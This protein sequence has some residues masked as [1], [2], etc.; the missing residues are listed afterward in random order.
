MSGLDDDEILAGLAEIE[1]VRAAVETYSREM[2]AGD[3]VSRVRGGASTL[4]KA[5]VGTDAVQGQ[6][7]NTLAKKLGRP[8]QPA[9]HLQGDL[10]GV[11]R[12]L[13]QSF[14]EELV[15]SHAVFFRHGDGRSRVAICFRVYARVGEL[16]C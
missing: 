13:Q 10:L 5:G 4:V 14:G 3:F 9:N 11:W 7:T 15:S 1:K 8:T 2:N 6:T 16:L 12:G